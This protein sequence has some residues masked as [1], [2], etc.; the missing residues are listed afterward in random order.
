MGILCGIGVGWI[1]L[2][3]FNMTESSTNCP[4]SFQLAK[5]SGTWLCTKNIVGC[6][7]IAI[8]LQ[9]IIFILKCEGVFTGYQRSSTDAFHPLITDI[10]GVM[11]MVLQP[12]LGLHIIVHL[13]IWFRLP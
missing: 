7:S 5:Q 10:N 8:P 1:R 3:K 12:H 11:L 6:C 2:G 13:V 9:G 4:S